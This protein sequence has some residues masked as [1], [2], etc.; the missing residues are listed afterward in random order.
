MS[1]VAAGNCNKILSHVDNKSKAI[2]LFPSKC[3]CSVTTDL[4]V[5]E[6]AGI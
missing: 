5:Q 6:R 4:Y 1:Y 3:K 2:Q